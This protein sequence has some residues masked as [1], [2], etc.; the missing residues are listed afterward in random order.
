MVISF[1][2]LMEDVLRP[3]INADHFLTALKEQSDVVMEA[4]D[5]ISI[6]A[7]WLTPLVLPVVLSDARSVPA[8]ETKT[9]ALRPMV[10][11]TWL[12]VNA[13]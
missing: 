7:H 4:V 13:L 6:C 2:V 10:V 1:L 3:Q 11:P 9:I 5:I 12:Q 8:S